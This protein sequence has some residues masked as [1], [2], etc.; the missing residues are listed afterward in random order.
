MRKKSEL[1]ARIERDWIDSIV[2]KTSDNLVAA[3]TNTNNP[4]SKPGLAALSSGQ[5]V[6]LI[7]GISIT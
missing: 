7:A 6:K 2:W 1:R 5:S 3:T 4:K